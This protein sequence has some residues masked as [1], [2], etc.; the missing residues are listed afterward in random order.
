MPLQ[1]QTPA[2]TS[3]QPTLH[4]VCGKIGAGKS[5]LSQRLACAPDT[6]LLSE[7]AWLAQ[8]YPSEITSVA[9]YAR[10]ARR[11]RGALTDHLCALLK[12]GMS[13]VLDFPA[14][15]P[16]ARAWMREVF[17]RAGVAHRLHYLNVPDAVCKARLHARNAAGTH[18]FTPSDAEF[19]EISRYFV[20]PSADEGFHVVRHT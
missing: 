2:A 1:S 14:N 15:T 20:A 9:D 4:L 19:D 8:L 13:V 10:C 3:T 12:A 5:T 6:V 7:D 11:L 16:T 18:P 17:E